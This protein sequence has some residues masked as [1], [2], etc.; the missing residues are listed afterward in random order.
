MKKKIGI[1]V[2]IIGIIAIMII[3]NLNKDRSGEGG[4]GGGKAQEVE[5]TALQRDDLF[6]SILITGTV[7]ESNK[8]EVISS[9]PLQIEEVL[10][11]VGD[12]VTTGQALF[13]VDMTDLEAE[14][15]QAM[16]NYEIQTLQL[17]KLRG[18]SSTST[19]TSGEIA[20][21]LSRLSVS[22]AEKYLEE[23]H[24]NLERSRILFS[25]GF[26]SE[27]EFK[28]MKKAVEEAENQLATSKL[29]LKRAED[30]LSALL[31]SNHQ[32]NQ[33]T[34]IDVTIQVKNLES[35]EMNI[36]TLENQ[37]KEIS[38]L[39][40]AIGDGIVTEVHI[41]EGEQS[42]TFAP[43]LTLMDMN[44]MKVAA[45]VRE[46]DIKDIILGQK[47]IITGDAI[48]QSASIEGE[49]S[50]IAPKAVQALVNGKEATT[51]PIEITITKDMN[52]L[53]PGYTADCEITTSYKEQVLVA[54]YDMFRDDRDNN[55]LAYVV[56]ENGIVEERIVVLGIT[57]DFDAEVLEGLE[58]GELVI[59]NPSLSLKDG[60]K[61]KVI[62]DLEKEGM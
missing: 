53:K 16:L 21:E 48:S 47:V 4:F 2:L 33:S 23:Q 55:K 19:A 3:Y 18:L 58:E 51:V 7:L 24:V 60:M 41:S 36:T 56:T 43:M 32:A 40:Y 45:N 38:D 42:P 52:Q 59:N 50:F 14:L 34:Q 26:I 44:K 46:Y 61:V 35:L 11:E 25:E 6:S 57:A 20:L 10:V 28:T 62:N 22:T 17:E 1:A 37:I 5:V 9:T 12:Q 8:L 49:V 29:N 27:E 15:K 54:S 31:E 13:V 30:D 39:T